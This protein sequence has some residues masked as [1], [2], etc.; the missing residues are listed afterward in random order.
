MR[1]GRDLRRGPPATGVEGALLRSLLDPHSP[2][3]NLRCP[4]TS[5]TASHGAP[6]LGGRSGC[7]GGGRGGAG[8]GFGAQGAGVKFVGRRG[9]ARC[10]REGEGEVRVRVLRLYMVNWSPSPS[11][12]ADG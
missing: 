9:A 4:F 11:D 10:D 12:A 6:R 1:E 2:A 7:G 5:T 8:V 3:F